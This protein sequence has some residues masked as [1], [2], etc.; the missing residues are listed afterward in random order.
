VSFG[1]GGSR[2]RQ[3]RD[4]SMALFPVHPSFTETSEKIEEGLV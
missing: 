4:A 2:S 1:S 3:R